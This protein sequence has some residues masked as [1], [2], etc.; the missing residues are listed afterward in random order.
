MYK[1]MSSTLKPVLSFRQTLLSLLNKLKLFILPFR[2]LEF[3]Y[4][5]NEESK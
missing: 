2:K 1:V 3:T 4:H 5:K